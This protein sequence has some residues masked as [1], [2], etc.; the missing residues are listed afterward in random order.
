MAIEIE[1]K[2]LVANDGWKSL[3]CRSMSI[4]QAYLSSNG[5][6]SA[7]VRIKGQGAGESATFT[8]KAARAGLQRAEFEYVIPTADALEMMP[9]RH[10]AIIEK[11]RHVVPF[12]GMEWEIDVFLGQNTGLT[13]AEVEL[14]TEDQEIALPS[15][16]G[17]EVTSDRRYYNSSLTVLP[18]SQWTTIGKEQV[19]KA[20]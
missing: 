15:W 3:V 9:L 10:G 12:E 8:I 17:A 1:R 11:V 16:I 7:R 20:K 18:F 2:F 14:Q 13:V 6:F 19:V 5:R 4:K